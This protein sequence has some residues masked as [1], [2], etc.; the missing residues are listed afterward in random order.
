MEQNEQTPSR[1]QQGSRTVRNVL[2]S[3]YDDVRQ[4]SKNLYMVKKR[5]VQS[6]IL[7]TE[8]PRLC[9][10]LQ[11]ASRYKNQKYSFDRDIGGKCYTKIQELETRAQATNAS[12]GD[13]FL[14][15]DTDEVSVVRLSRAGV[16]T[17]SAKVYD[18]DPKGIPSIFEYGRVEPCFTGK[19]DLRPNLYLGVDKFTN[20]YLSTMLTM[21]Y[22]QGSLFRSN[23]LALSD[24]RDEPVTICN[25]SQSKFG[26]R[27]YTT[28]GVMCREHCPATGLTTNSILNAI[29]SE[30]FAAYSGRRERFSVLS[31]DTVRNIVVQMYG[32]MY[33][34]YSQHQFVHGNLTPG[35]V[36]LCRGDGSEQEYYSVRY[37][38]NYIPKIKNLQYASSTFRDNSGNAVRVFNSG[39]LSKSYL[40]VSP[41][42]P[43]TSKVYGQP[44]YSF[45]SSLTKTTLLYAQHAGTPYYRSFDLYTFMI[46]MMHYTW[47]LMPILQNNELRKAFWD[48]LWLEER[49]KEKVEKRLLN[50]IDKKNEPSIEN[51]VN[52]LSGV[53]LKCNLVEDTWKVLRGE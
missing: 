39:I 41:F 5:K 33:E 13:V 11:V 44:Y 30:E 52:I 12:E 49:D 22:L 14:L 28:F 17:L 53:Q 32:T 24:S 51:I 25:P 27:T 2:S 1:M 18:K 9:C 10:V 7:N 15:D 35:N 21:D 26:F 3:V 42:L 19:F 37:T 16:T 29:P 47:F 23:V 6:N 31:A 34:L 8:A 36:A 38:T 20:D 40:R 43:K 46:G 45:D 4:F 48:T 50:A